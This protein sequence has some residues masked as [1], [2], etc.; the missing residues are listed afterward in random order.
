MATIPSN[1]ILYPYRPLEKTNHIRL[2]KLLP[3]VKSQKVDCQ[4]MPVSLDSN[5]QYEALSYAWGKSQDQHLTNPIWIDNVQVSI[6]ENLYHALLALRKLSQARILWVDAICINQRDLEERGSQIQQMS[7]IY[8][9]AERVVT[10]IGLNEGGSLLAMSF[11][12]RIYNVIFPDGQD[13]DPEWRKYP[14]SNLINDPQNMKSWEAL[15]NF[16]N[17]RY[18]T[19][20]WI[21]Q[22]IALASRCIL[23]C[24]DKT[25]EWDIFQT[26]CL[27]IYRPNVLRH[28]FGSGDELIAVIRQSLAVT[29][30]KLR[31][32][33][34]TVYP[35]QYLLEAFEP[36]RCKE[37]KDKIFAILGLIDHSSR[38]TLVADYKKSLF[39]L[40]V[41]VVWFMLYSYESKTPL[42]KRYLEF[43]KSL[44]R[45]S[46]CVQR[47]LGD[48]SRDIERD[49]LETLSASLPVSRSV[50]P[51]VTLIQGLMGGSITHLHTYTQNILSE[52]VA[53]KFRGLPSYHYRPEKT[54]R[55]TAI[56][57]HGLDIFDD[58]DQAR[59]LSFSSRISYGMM[60]WVP[61]QYE[62]RDEAQ[63]SDGGI[64]TGAHGRNPVRRNSLEVKRP[65][66]VQLFLEKSGMMGV[67]PAEAKPR[68][69]I[70]H[71][72][73]CDVA[74]VVRPQG[75]KLLFI[76]RALVFNREGASSMRLNEET[77]KNFK[78][79]VPNDEEFPAH[80]N[81]VSFYVDVAT[82]QLLTR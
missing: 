45:V 40:W 67:V 53:E 33:R 61:L 35:L 56:L 29:Y 49:V 44:V 76:G 31:S 58:T 7:K 59:V 13:N 73:N 14:M 20:R 81:G 36:S 38:E 12:E 64:L 77:N 18:W 4:L 5:P 42:G 62:P 6:Q 17:R 72:L 34:R 74:A 60:G 25:L 51:G 48:V 65:G 21:I 55:R 66:R 3:G 80:T 52:E 82:L 2:L 22:E 41:D 15:A 75:D 57:Q 43:P 1:H 11:I 46:Q 79:L 30:A 37:P 68:D 28:E 54:L 39:E 8:G 9:Q 16:C 50:A 47:N 26:V 27:E 63:V 24:G 69:M 71:F 19:R 32:Q 78:Y 23:Q 70:C 10:W